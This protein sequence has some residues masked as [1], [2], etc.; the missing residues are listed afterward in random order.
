LKLRAFCRG[1]LEFYGL[2][3]WLTISMSTT[4]SGQV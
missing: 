4:R 1:L 3:H 2:R